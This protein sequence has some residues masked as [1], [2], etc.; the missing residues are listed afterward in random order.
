MVAG[1]YLLF[2]SKPIF[3]QIVRKP[4][5]PIYVV[6]ES[7]RVEALSPGV[8]TSMK[9]LLQAGLHRDRKRRPTVEEVRD[10]LIRPEDAV[11]LTREIERQ[12]AEGRGY[13]VLEVLKDG[14][15]FYADM[16]GDEPEIDRE[17]IV[18]RRRDA[19]LHLAS[20][21]RDAVPEQWIGRAILKHV[22]QNVGHFITLGKRWQEGRP[23]RDPF[24][25]AFA[26]I[27]HLFD[28]GTPAQ[29]I[30][31]EKSTEAIAK[32]DIVLKRS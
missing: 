25:E 29:W 2:T 10:C 15:A 11:F 7:P 31:Y 12:A 16:A 22:H 9:L 14:A 21:N 20:Y 27:S 17:Y 18:V 4:V 24:R 28:P 23:P 26:G 13:Q 6:L 32:G 8:P 1:F 30:E 19:K 3:H 5:I